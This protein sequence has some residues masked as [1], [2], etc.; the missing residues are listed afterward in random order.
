[1]IAKYPYAEFSSDKLSLRDKLALARTLLANERTFLAYLRT[2]LAIFIAG[3]SL[4]QFFDSITLEIVGWFFIQLGIITI[5]VGSRR[6]G[7]MAKICKLQ[8]REQAKREEGKT[9]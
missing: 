7:K 5:Y 9:G 1:M 4:I 3:V 2:A 8:V 6:F